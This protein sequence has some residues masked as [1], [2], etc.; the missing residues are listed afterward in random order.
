MQRRRQR[1][2]IDGF[3]LLNKPPGISSNRAL[4]QMRG[5]LNAARAGHAGTLDP[6][7]SGLLPLA[8]GE[9]TKFCGFLLEADKGYVAR[10]Q[11]GQRTDSGDAEGQLLE[12]CPVTV[13][14][15]QIERVVASFAGASEQI[16]PMYSALKRDGK[17]LYAYAR[18]GLEVERKPRPVR[19]EQ[20]A[21]ADFDPRENRFTLHVRCSKGTYIR[22]LAEDIGQRLG[23]GAHL[24]ALCRNAVGPLTLAQAHDPGQLEALPADE[25]LRCLHALDM[26]LQHLPAL[27]LDARQAGAL[28]QGQSVMAAAVE[29]AGAGRYRLYGAGCFFGL[30]EIRVDDQRIYPQRLLAQDKSAVPPA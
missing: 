24:V 29:N 8:F 30:G 25:R 2:A 18:A 9:A 3:L 10:V 19:I 12:Q 16:P 20:I 6:L 7:A 22:T 13:D 15:A 11:L 23:C 28:R 1:Q 4:Q 14:A 5:L 17:P 26:P 27:K 21:A